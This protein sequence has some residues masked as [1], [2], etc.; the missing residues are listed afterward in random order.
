MEA[1]YNNE[2]GESC[3]EHGRSSAL[4]RD[5]R[6]LENMTRQFLQLF[7][8]FDGCLLDEVY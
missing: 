7:S 5:S 6:Y 1:H 8:V 3:H 4:T 2:T